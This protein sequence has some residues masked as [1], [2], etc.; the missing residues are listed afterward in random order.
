MANNFY[1]EGFETVFYDENEHCFKMVD[2][3]YDTDKGLRLYPEL[4]EKFH[5]ILDLMNKLSDEEIT[6]Y[7]VTKDNPFGGSTEYYYFFYEGE[8]QDYYDELCSYQGG[9]SSFDDD[10]G[11]MDYGMGEETM[12]LKEFINEEA[13]NFDVEDVLAYIKSLP[14]PEETLKERA[15]E[16]DNGKAFAVQDSLYSQ[17]THDALGNKDIA[18]KNGSKDPHLTSLEKD[19]AVKSVEVLKQMGKLDDINKEYNVSH[20]PDLVYIPVED[21]VKVTPDN[22]SR[23]YKIKIPEA[24]SFLKF[25]EYDILDEGVAVFSKDKIDECINSLKENKFE[26]EKI[27]EN[28]EKYGYLK[29]EVIILKLK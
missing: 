13:F 6:I 27:T 24:L 25:Y 22:G 9:R 8:A 26:V 7:T 1:E 12:T 5:S 3:H 17:K 16:L 18:I 10:D 15:I 23:P 4:A 19:V 2:D 21:A 11:G 14:E 29:D 28:L 20:G